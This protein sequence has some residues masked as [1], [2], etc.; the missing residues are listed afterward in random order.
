[1]RLAASQAKL[2]LKM[3]GQNETW[4]TCMLGKA[5]KGSNKTFLL[6]MLVKEFPLSKVSRCSCW[7]ALQ[8]IVEIQLTFGSFM[9]LPVRKLPPRLVF[10]ISIAPYV[11][12]KPWGHWEVGKEMSSK[13]GSA[14]RSPV[15]LRVIITEINQPLFHTFM[16][17]T[18]CQLSV[19]TQKP[20]TDLGEQIS[21]EGIWAATIIHF[22]F[23]GL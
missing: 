18:V 7:D 6:G 9:P 22:A 23:G 11:G 4:P 1:M 12:E 5:N 21:D 20:R 17:I 14:A 8:C 19:M 2:H 10:C 16:L 13:F 3:N 15:E